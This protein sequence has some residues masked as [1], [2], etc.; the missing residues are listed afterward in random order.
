MQ[1]TPHNAHLFPVINTISYSSF[2][3]YK[4][5]C[6]SKVTA[7]I[8]VTFEIYIINKENNALHRQTTIG[9]IINGSAMY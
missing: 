5:Y 4:E 6:I 1:V 2:I 3:W 8:E 7:T 9:K